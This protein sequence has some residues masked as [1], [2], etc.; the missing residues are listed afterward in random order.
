LK[1]FFYILVII[2]ISNSAFAVGD[3]PQP[4]SDDLM[5]NELKLYKSA[6]G[7]THCNS[8]IPVSGVISGGGLPGLRSRYETMK[9]ATDINS[10]PQAEL[11]IS[12]Q[13]ETDPMVTEEETTVSFK[14]IL[15]KN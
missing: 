4:M 12:W 2:L 7:P 1:V 10:K 6:I 9:L 5:K 11:T 8:L 14:C 13:T 15:L 3:I